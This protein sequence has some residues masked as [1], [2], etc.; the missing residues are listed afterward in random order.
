M[1][2]SRDSE[3][4]FAIRDLTFQPGHT[5]FTVHD[6]SVKWGFGERFQRRFHVADGRW[7]I[8][9]RDKPWKIDEGRGGVSEQTYG[10]H[11]LYLAR[12]RQSKLYHLAYFK[13]THGLLVES[14]SNSN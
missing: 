5:T 11:P 13:N 8:W 2:R 3:T 14:N 1:K 12:S 10:H 6:Q 7:T 4:I 9:N